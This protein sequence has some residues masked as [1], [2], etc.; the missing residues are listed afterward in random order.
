[1]KKVLDVGQCAMDHGAIRRYLETGFQ[2]NV[3]QAHD[4]DDALEALSGAGFDLVLINRV[5]DSDGSDGLEI[6]RRIK[7]DPRLSATPV[8]LVTNFPEY[9]Q[10]AIAAGAEPG[11]GKASLQQPATRE[12][13][14]PFLES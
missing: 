11:F 2:A 6:V 7:S 4:A 13:L 3:T 10:Q 14:K 9:Q 5:L 12:R 1:M 8:M